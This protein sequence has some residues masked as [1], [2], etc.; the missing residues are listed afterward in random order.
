MRCKKT[1]EKVEEAYQI[2][3]SRASVYHGRGRRGEEEGEGREEGET[4]E[5]V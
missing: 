1:L 4:G 2:P 3:T 5:R